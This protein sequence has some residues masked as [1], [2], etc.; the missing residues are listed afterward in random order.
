MTLAIVQRIKIKQQLFLGCSTFGSAGLQSQM[1]AHLE[2][3]LGKINSLIDELSSK[4]L[5]IL[6]AYKNKCQS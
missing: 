5:Q 3:T 6:N 4:K 2:I 1:F